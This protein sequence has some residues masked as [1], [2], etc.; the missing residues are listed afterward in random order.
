MYVLGKNQ[1]AFVQPE[2]LDRLNRNEMEYYREVYKNS[3]RWN[4]VEPLD[5]KRI[6]VYCEQGFGDIIHFSRYFHFLKQRNCEVALHCPKDLHRLFAEFDCPMIDRYE[7]ELPYHDFHTLSMSLP[8]N[9]DHPKIEFPYLHV[10]NA[11][12]LSE[13]GLPEKSIKV[14]V[15]WEGN[16][17]HSNNGER[18]CPL[19]YFKKLAENLTTLKM[20]KLHKTIHTPD[21]ILGSED[22]ELYGADIVDFQDTA[23]LIS[24]MD[25]IIT[26]DTS[27]LHLAGA[28][29]K[30]SYG[31]LSFNCDPRWNIDIN[32]YPSIKFFKQRYE[33]DWQD[34]FENL[35]QE[36]EK[37]NV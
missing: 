31:L 18:C 28:L 4:G 23:E 24:A 20:F 1:G 27:I 22:M 26:V 12:D 8:F 32:W 21:L 2:C 13:I 19:I 15:A 29:N 33:G 36:L 16:P 17:E 3:E 10:E 30:P 5:G 34:V 35:Q 25:L 11:I 7:S 6:I 14:G 9:L 37:I